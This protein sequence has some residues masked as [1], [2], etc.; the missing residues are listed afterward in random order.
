MQGRWGVDAFGALSSPRR[1]MNYF[2]CGRTLVRHRRRVGLKPDLQGYA[3]TNYPTGARFTWY[4]RA[5]DR[6]LQ[7]FVQIAHDALRLFSPALVDGL[8]AARSRCQ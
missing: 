2:C 5:F 6:P 8:A 3:S 7:S 4:V 1:S